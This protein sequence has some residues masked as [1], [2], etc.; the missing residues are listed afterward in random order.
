MIKQ[1]QI[2]DVLFQFYQKPIAKVTFELFLSIGAVL[3]FAIFAIRPTLLTMSDLIKEIEDKRKLDQQLTQ[4]IAALSSAQSIYLNLQD[5]L[6]VLDEAIPSAPK[7]I[8]ALKIIEKIAS[9]Q[10]VVISGITVNE[11]PVE[12]PVV[13]GDK[14]VERR[15]LPVSLT[16]S[17]DFG[18]IKRFIEAL[19][20]VRRAL[21]VDTVIF[22]K[23]DERG[24]A[25]LKVTISLSVPYYGPKDTT[26][27]GAS[28]KTK[29]AEP[30]I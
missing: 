21:I 30:G 14:S 28:T 20:R 12:Q 6:T 4:K 3:F 27:D 17:G 24:R 11:V 26:T 8:E 15:G 23:S 13:V 25:T 22:T 1:K 29:T 7:F 9:E 5:R 2:T 10:Q 18:S 16:V 19:Q